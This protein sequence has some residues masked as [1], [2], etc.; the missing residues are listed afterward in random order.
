MYGLKWF[1][2]VARWKCCKLLTCGVIS[3]RQA[4]P[5]HY[6]DNKKSHGN[7]I[8][9]ICQLQY[10]PTSDYIQYIARST[11]LERIIA[12]IWLAGL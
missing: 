10:H 4:E 9:E 2:G 3:L 6:Q 8:Q 1:E 11:R 12:A 7:F 5:W